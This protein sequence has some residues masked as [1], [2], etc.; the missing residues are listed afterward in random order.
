MRLG[1]HVSIA[2]KLYESLDR[3]EA[4]G[5]QTMQIFSRNPRGW[6]LKGVSKKEVKEFKRRRR[7]AGIRPLIVHIPYHINL[8]S[9][10]EVLYKRS[11][12]YYI[13][14]IKYAGML[15]AD[16]FVTHMGSHKGRGEEFGLKRLSEALNLIIKRMN[17]ELQIL[18]E[19]TAGSGNRLGYKFEHLGYVINRI[20]NTKSLGICFDTAHAFEAG[21]DI[22]TKDGL[23]DTLKEIEANIGLDRLKLI[24][25]NDS[26]TSLKSRRDRHENIGEGKIGLAAFK[27]IVNHPKLKDLP[28]ILETPKMQ[29]ESDKNNLDIVRKLADG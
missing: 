8:A 13:E 2:G 4:L 21:Y 19:I 24:H 5:C 16:Y 15:E 6:K 12:R 10:D 29:F 9:P 11:I 27:R 7:D 3:A 18:L 26:K 14:D 23:D 20:K 1:V 17:P 25:I 28:F 22:R